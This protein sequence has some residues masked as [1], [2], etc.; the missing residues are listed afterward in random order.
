[1][2]LSIV[3]PFCD[4]DFNFLEN[5]IKQIKQNVKI[6]H[7]IVLIDN[8]END[9]TDITFPEVKIFSQHKNLGQFE[10][11]LYAVQFCQGEYVWYVDADDYVLEVP[12]K[13]ESVKSDI[14]CFNVYENSKDGIKPQKE[15][16]KKSP[17]FVKK[18]YITLKTQDYPFT[19]LHKFVKNA[20]WSCWI[21]AT[22]MQSVAQ[23][24]PRNCNFKHNEDIFTQSV[25]FTKAETI[26]FC[27]DFFYTYNLKSSY[28][29]NEEYSVAKFTYL[30]KDMLNLH[31]AAKNVLKQHYYDVF[32]MFKDAFFA[33]CYILKLPEKDREQAVILFLKYFG[34]KNILS[35]ISEECDSMH[36]D[37]NFI[38]QINKVLCLDLKGYNQNY[39]DKIKQLKYTD[40]GINSGIKCCSKNSMEIL[41]K[42]DLLEFRKCCN[43]P[44]SEILGTIKIKD[45]L[46]IKNK[47]NYLD[48]MSRTI[49]PDHKWWFK[50]ME[51]NCN[52][53]TCCYY[54]TEKLKKITVTHLNCNINCAMCRGERIYN[55]EEIDN[56]F[57]ILEAIKGNELEN[58]HLANRGE[59]FLF[60]EKTFKFLE[61]LSEKDCKLILI[62]TNATLLNRSDI[63][64]LAALKVPP[65][66]TVSCDGITYDTYK[67]IR[68]NNF[69]DTVIDNIQYMALKKVLNVV[70]IVISN[71]NLHELCEMPP[72]F[73]KLGIPL[74]KQTY[75]LCATQHMQFFDNDF[76]KIIKSKEFNQFKKL[77][78]KA[79]ISY[80][81]CEV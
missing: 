68:R 9:T 35:F 43:L 73:E 11:R 18:E 20:L 34:V 55:K 17:L 46:K 30:Y 48:A 29:Y 42:G 15:A 37:S 6:S 44:A 24:M 1:M 72:F 75:I 80:P 4:K 19:V 62:I 21:R 56:Y 47:Y 76:E 78:P 64:R 32:N 61:S 51:L 71:L 50:S 40:V 10:A 7:E 36:F 70:N 66:V 28:G 38:A 67:S 26:L 54:S 39:F 69:F 81:Y 57:K 27:K 22:I 2:K 60:K 52:G 25:A 58:I 16:E 79:N 5:L 13:Y 59:P 45:F 53:T 49:P 3:I 65:L 77:Y 41:I 8:R 33:S 74:Q 14:I 23:D 31:N 12:A 63:D